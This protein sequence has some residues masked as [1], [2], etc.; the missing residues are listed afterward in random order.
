MGGCINNFDCLVEWKHT[1]KDYDF[2]MSNCI[3]IAEKYFVAIIEA[4]ANHLTEAV[5]ALVWPSSLRQFNIP[6]FK[7]QGFHWP[8]YMVLSVCTMIASPKG[9]LAC[10]H[11]VFSLF[12]VFYRDQKF[13]S[14]VE[15]HLVIMV[16]KTRSWEISYKLSAALSRFFGKQAL[17]ALMIRV[18]L[19]KFI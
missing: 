3:N 7:A 9:W 4:W 1:K 12:T 13:A 14:T 8:D 11:L 18:D 16:G 17:Y 15:L 6:P 2:S 5:V 19:H 10:V